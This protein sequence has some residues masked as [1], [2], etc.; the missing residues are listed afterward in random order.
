MDGASHSILQLGQISVKDANTLLV[1]AFA[2]EHA[3]PIREAIEKSNLGV[4]PQQ[5]QRFVLIP[6][7]KYVACRL[8]L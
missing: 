7:P 2:E 5:D 1:T 8:T 4:T 3:K 6:I